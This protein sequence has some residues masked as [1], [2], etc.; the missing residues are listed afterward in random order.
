MPATSSILERSIL[1]LSSEDFVPVAATVLL[2]QRPVMVVGDNLY[3][4]DSGDDFA[5][6]PVVVILE[7]VGISVEGQARDGTLRIN[8][9]STKI[10]REIWPVIR[11]T[12]GAIIEIYAG[13]QSNSAEDPVI[14]QGPFNYVLGTDVSVQPLIEGVYL[15]LRFRSENQPPWS[16]LAVKLDVDPTGEP[17]A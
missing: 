8:P 11:G 2:D 6:L 10:L 7:K 16:L 3:R 5:G 15:A 9:S 14:W 13:S 1:E 17:F 4:A 12:T